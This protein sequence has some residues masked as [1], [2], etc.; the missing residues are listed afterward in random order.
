[1]WMCPLTTFFTP[2]Q[3]TG[4]TKQLFLN[5]IQATCLYG[6]YTCGTLPSACPLHLLDVVEEAA[7][8]HGG[9]LE[10]RHGTNFYII[11]QSCDKLNETL[12]KAQAQ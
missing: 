3:I 7:K 2:N 10:N 6:L 8:S 11:W 5:V 1:M 4:A 9:V 12:Q